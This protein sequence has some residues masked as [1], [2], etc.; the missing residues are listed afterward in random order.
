MNAFGAE[1]PFC[2]FRQLPVLLQ[3]RRN[4]AGRVLDWIAQ[5]EVPGEYALFE[6][7]DWWNHRHLHGEI[8][9]RTPAE[10]EAPTMLNPGH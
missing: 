3:L 6:D 10:K 8:G 1:G 9:M 5:A 7:L 4:N 2:S